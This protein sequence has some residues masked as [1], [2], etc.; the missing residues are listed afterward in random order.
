[1]KF[2]FMFLILMTAALAQANAPSSQPASQSPSQLPTS[3]PSF[4]RKQDI[5]YGR[6]FGTALTLDI[7]KPTGPANGKAV[8]LVVSGGWVSAHETIDSPLFLIFSHPLT[9]RGYTVFAVCHGCQPRFQIPEIVDNI[10]RA[11]RFI[12]YHAKEYGIDPDHIGITGASAGGHLSLMQGLRPK[13]GNKDAADPIERVSSNVQ[14]VACFFPP[15]D[16][17]NWG[18]KNINVLDTPNMVP[19][20]PAF[21]FHEL[22]KSNLYVRILDRLRVCEI[23]KSVSPIYG[24]SA[25]SAPTLILHGDADPLVPI[26]QSQKLIKKLQEAN[27]PA[28]LFTKPG[29]SH[30][31]ADVGKDME[32]VV[33]WFDQHLLPPKM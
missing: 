20:R 3:L 2:M 12:R 28:E 1:M 10:N 24:V 32:R 17:L 4:T 30:G 33:N 5:V 15:T 19:F 22:D 13:P 25:D 26:E 6:T 16:F 29:A 21:D 31:W 7:F 27:V 18:D 9:S 14:A 8:I 23:E 11:V